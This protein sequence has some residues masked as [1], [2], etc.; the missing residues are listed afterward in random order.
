M[1]HLSWG[2][3]VQA[4][5]AMP[6]GD[7]SGGGAADRGRGTA[8]HQLPWTACSP[9][10]AT[11]HPS[12][13]SLG[14]CPAPLLARACSSS[15]LSASP[16][17]LLSLALGGRWMSGVY[18]LPGRR[19]GWGCFTGGGGAAWRFRLHPLAAPSR[20]QLLSS[21]PR[22]GQ[23]L[24]CTPRLRMGRGLCRHPCPPPSTPPPHPPPARSAP[25]Q[26]TSCMRASAG[27]R[28]A[29]VER[30]RVLLGPEYEWNWP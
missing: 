25:P 19:A 12:P 18:V 8:P 10:S 21:H 20:P 3:G 1:Q 6:W 24:T 4:L 7:H 28:E 11:S 16:S 2:W 9:V 29:W 13:R 15:S 5:G 14:G 23:I 22:V 26:S 27:P 30:G 17:L